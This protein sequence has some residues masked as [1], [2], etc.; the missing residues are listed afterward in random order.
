MSPS[1]KRSRDELQQL[2]LDFIID[3]KNA[4]DTESCL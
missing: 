3:I 1:E 4:I 2:G